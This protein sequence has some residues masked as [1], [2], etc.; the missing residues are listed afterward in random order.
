M[1]DEGHTAFIRSK[2]RKPNQR[3]TKIEETSSDTDSDAQDNSDTLRELYELACATEKIQIPRKAKAEIASN[4]QI[5]YSE[6]LE[7]VSLSEWVVEGLPAKGVYVQGVRRDCGNLYWHSNIIVHR[8]GAKKLKTMSG[9]IYELV[10]PPDKI[11]MLQDGYPSWLVE[12]FSSG[13]PNDWKKYVNCFTDVKQMSKEPE[14]H[15]DIGSSRENDWMQ[16]ESRSKEAE[17]LIDVRRT[18]GYQ[19]GQ[20]K[21]SY[22][23][24][25]GSKES[26]PH[27]QVGSTR[28]T[29]RSQKESRSK[30]SG[31]HVQVGSTRENARSQK[32]SRSKESEPHVQVG[33]TRENARSQKESRHTEPEVKPVKYPTTDSA[34]REKQ[35]IENCE[36]P[37]QDSNEPRISRKVINKNG[38]LS[39]EIRLLKSYYSVDSNLNKENSK[40][41]RLSPKS[42]ISVTS[43]FTDNSVTSRSG[44]QIKPVLK[45]WCGERLSV[46]FHG[47]TTV[48][49]GGRDVLTEE[50][51]NMQK[52]S[53]KNGVQPKKCAPSNKQDKEGFLVQRTKK[54]RSTIQSPKTNKQK[55]FRGQQLKS[56]K[57]MVTS[58][59]SKQMKKQ[60]RKYQI[61]CEDLGESTTG[62][63][64]S[65]SDLDAQNNPPV[66]K[67]EMNNNKASCDLSEVV[68]SNVCSQL[69]GSVKESCPYSSNIVKANTEVVKT[70][71]LVGNLSIKKNNSSQEI[72]K[73]ADPPPSPKTNI[74][75]SLRSARLHSNTQDSEAATC[76]SSVKKCGLQRLRKSARLG[77]P[78]RLTSDSSPLASIEETS[79]EHSPPSILKKVVL[80]DSALGEKQPS[81]SKE[82]LSDSEQHEIL[83]DPKPITRNKKQVMSEPLLSRKVLPPRRA[84]PVHNLAEPSSAEESARHLK[85]SHVRKTKLL[86]P[87]LNK[88]RPSI[89]SSESEASEEEIHISKV[90]GR[91][92]S[93]QEKTS[94]EVA[95][96]RKAVEEPTHLEK[97]K[98]SSRLKNKNKKK[99]DL[100]KKQISS[101]SSETLSKSEKE[102][103]LQSDN[104]QSRPN[105]R[106]PAHSTKLQANQSEESNQS[107]SE[108]SDVQTSSRNNLRRQGNLRRNT[109]ISTPGPV[110]SKPLKNSRVSAEQRG[111]SVPLKNNKDSQKGSKPRENKKK[112]IAFEES[113]EADDVILAK[114]INGNQTESDDLDF[115]TGPI[116][117]VKSKKSS[118]VNKPNNK[119]KVLQKSQENPRVKKIP[120]L[121]AH[122][123]SE[124]RNPYVNA[125]EAMAQPDKWT[126]KEVQRLHKAVS[127]LP[128]HKKEFWVDVAMAVGSRS[129]LECQE[130]YWEDQMKGTK[131]GQDEKSKKKKE[132]KQESKGKEK[133]P[134]KI[135]SKVGTLKRKKQMREFLDQMGKDNY[136]DMFTATPYQDKR[137]RL[138]TMNETDE[139]FA[140]HLSEGDLSTPASSIFPLN[141]TPQCDHLTPGMLRSIDRSANEKYV[142]RLQKT[143]RGGQFRV[144]GN[145]NKK[146]KICLDAT[147][148]TRRMTSVHS[149]SKD[150]SV[151]GKLFKND[152]P[153]S[154]DEEEE[155]E[156]D[157]YF[158]DSSSEE[159]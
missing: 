6:P 158:P 108:E 110:R 157:Y 75:R 119:S 22:I 65:E 126:E 103:G 39:R 63:S 82:S 137:V 96:K 105:V 78:N 141:G 37:S 135:T 23:S 19:G 32:E 100:D 116:R 46:D 83:E 101:L 85:N 106:L 18:R 145:I 86:R 66:E 148:T 117:K 50:I 69:T 92:S 139:E 44:R 74:K 57:V 90:S 38:T 26:G 138:P 81:E 99:S 107:D 64:A 33:S 13:F 45:F 102:S 54:T 20:V 68:E 124:C 15:F 24:M 132:K 113:S 73:N 122:S 130:K 159:A 118:E 140:F 150:T 80:P 147:P 97:E 111:P 59:T 152:G 48:I 30:E 28:E 10:G 129:A 58:L 94:S 142:Y 35:E 51:E 131:E 128:K 21:K 134:I 31:P 109:L 123:K 12:K 149:G 55:E 9:R 49:K 52:K 17:T 40:S 136:D 84:K 41:S 144:R 14:Q 16:K 36:R 155:E 61:H 29:A 133:E 76:K 87:A 62:S 71:G 47:N 70:S 88:K 43:H 4:L 5:G 143:L 53:I 127:S 151:I 79:E 60:C 25:M 115:I 121:A 93:I 125:F 146:S 67:Q 77:V 114:T 153:S 42:D 112:P 3:P 91:P 72:L 27:V 1:E 154:S 98:R 2:V 11:S 95:P 104:G 7:A 120:K 8:I 89:Q 156:K 34:V 56:P